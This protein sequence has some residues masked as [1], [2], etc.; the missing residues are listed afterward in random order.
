MCGSSLHSRGLVRGDSAY[1]NVTIMSF[2]GGSMVKHPPADA[3]DMDSIPDS[4]RSH[5]LQSN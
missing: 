1:F 4:G 3:G 5:M 2:P